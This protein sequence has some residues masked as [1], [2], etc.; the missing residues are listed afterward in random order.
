MDFLDPNKLEDSA[1]DSL[2]LDLAEQ[3]AMESR[4]VELT[5]QLAEL[6]EQPRPQKK[7]ALL[8]EMAHNLAALERGADAWPLAREALDLFLQQE[9]WE[10]AAEA[11]NVLYQSEQT[12]SLAALG[13]GI[14]L[15]VTYPINPEIT[16]ELLHHLIEDTPDESDGA[17]VAAAAAAF[18]VDLRTEPGQLR[19][20]LLFF[21]QQ[22]LGKV[23]RRHSSVDNSA[24]FDYW[25]ERLELDQ[26]DKFLVRLRNIIDVLVQDQWWFDR[27]ELQSRLP[28]G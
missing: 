14:W 15:A 22:M 28:E 3:A 18:I 17:A 19:D 26:P 8:L 12:G 2:H 4:L 20:D 9:S 25:I 7:A 6:G 23:A 1:V 10:Q 21:T 16:V 11:C 27:D 5:Q 13:Q 24:Q